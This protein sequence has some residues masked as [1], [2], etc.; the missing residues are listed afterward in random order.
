MK[1]PIYPCLWFDGQAKAAAD[2]YVEAFADAR[3][4]SEGSMV[5]TCTLDGQK[6]MGLNGG[7][8]YKPN[9]S[10]SLY[11]T[12]DSADEVERA[13]AVLSDGGK[14]LMPLDS[15]PWSSK[16]GWVQDRFGI[17]WQLALGRKKDVGQ[18][19]APMLMFT[20]DQAGRAEQAVRFYTSVFAPSS[21]VGIKRYGPNEA[22][23]E[24]TVNHAQ[25]WLGQQVFMA[26]DSSFPHGFSFSEGISLVV[27]CESQQEI[28]G[29]WT[30]LTDG[31][32]ESQCGWLKDRFGVSWQVVP[33]I[34]AELLADKA[35]APRVTQA[36]LEMKKLDI[37]TLL[38]A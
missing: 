16:Y 7:P 15:Y 31:G 20:G 4:T 19:I 28:D 38:N 11:T 1:G 37:A 5:V 22:D 2:A 35:R 21:I 25:F 8:M 3:I 36:F 6:L 27:T 29:Y 30:Q 10:I 14:V 26:I 12:C 9:P 18:K 33:S 13:W 32:Q 23:K 24:G 34:L 17:S